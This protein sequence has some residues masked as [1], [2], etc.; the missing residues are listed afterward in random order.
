MRLQQTREQAIAY[1]EEQKQALEQA[2]QDA[3]DIIEQSKQTGR[4][5]ADR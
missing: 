1:V 4:K 3:Y 5:Q 2:R